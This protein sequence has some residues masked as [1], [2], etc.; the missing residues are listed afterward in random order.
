MSV[1]LWVGIQCSRG[2]ESAKSEEP[3]DTLGERTPHRFRAEGAEGEEP[4]ATPWVCVQRTVS[5]LKVRKEPCALSARKDHFVILQD[6][7][8]ALC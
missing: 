1:V 2:T 5:A 8:V 3:S 4:R 7:G 6:Q